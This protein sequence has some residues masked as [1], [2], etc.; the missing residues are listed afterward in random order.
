MVVMIVVDIYLEI[1]G[2]RGRM[3]ESAKKG[4]NEIEAEV[5]PIRQSSLMMV[6]LNRL[7]IYP[8]QAAANLYDI[9]QYANNVSGI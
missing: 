8:V 3:Y 1:I 6:V 4:W 5:Q 2:D 7:L 9:S